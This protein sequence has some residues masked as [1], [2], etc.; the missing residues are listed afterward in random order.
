MTDPKNLAKTPPISFVGRVVSFEYQDE[1]VNGE[2]WGWR[3]KVALMNDLTSSRVDTSDDNVKT[4]LALIP[5]DAGSGAA[6]C[7]KS[8]KIRQ[9]DVV[10]GHKIGGGEPYTHIILGLFGRNKQT[11]NGEGRFDCESGYTE[12][13][14]QADGE[15]S[16]SKETTGPAEQEPPVQLPKTKASQAGR[17]AA[18]GSAVGMKLTPANTCENTTL[19]NIEEALENLIKFIQEKQG[20]LSEYQDK[21]DE[22]AELIKASLSWL[23]GEIM[24]AI[25][26]FLVGDDNK[27]GIIPVA[28]NAL[29][30]SV[31]AAIVSTAG[32]AAAHIAASKAIEAFVIPISALEAALICVANALLEGLVTLIRELLLSMLENIDRFVTCI[33]DQFVGS[34]LNSVVDRIA[35]GL[36]GALGGLSSLLGGA[37]DI[38]SVAKDAISFFNSLGGLLDCNQVNTK[39]DGTKEWIIGQGPK[40]A[41]DITQSFDNIFN[42]VNTAGAL[43]NDVINTIEGVPTSIQELTG[44]ITDVVDI[45]NGDSLI[46]GRT[47]NFGNCLTTYPTSCGSAQIK[48]FGG[49]GTGGSAIPILGPTIE[50]IINDTSIGQNVT[51]TANIIGAVV[52]NAGSGY[53][54]P[55]FVEI[56]DECGIGYGAKARSTINNEGQI[57]S[58]YMVSSGENYPINGET[59][60]GVVDVVVVSSGIG[61]KTTD[62]AIDNFGNE[63]SLTIDTDSSTTGTGTGGTGTGGT[64]GTGTGGTDTLT[65][66][67]NITGRILS[68][69]LINKVEVPDLV[70]IRINSETGL[71]AVLK[72]ILGKIDGSTTQEEVIQV[73]DCIS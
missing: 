69:S 5:N 60:Y 17:A 7:A 71:G 43:A 57:T 4:A 16:T 48:I 50:R 31:Y 49:G 19:T 26:D 18:G 23:V 22:V 39:C 67:T 34:L 9:G 37:I 21:I 30:T 38:I 12:R 6:N 3:Y 14:P 42:V 58:I 53:R 35:D 64:G 66:D 8:L 55:P 25:T 46:E 28:L 51:K 20:K 72:P 54:F 44:G 41:M 29:Y 68:V 59:G 13:L 62:T 73:I 70:T 32:P 11:K 61:Y 47:G 27:P 40:D 52:E 33:V 45:F 2:G 10:Y 1:Q 56:T 63:Y 36:S 15:V 65:T 24:K